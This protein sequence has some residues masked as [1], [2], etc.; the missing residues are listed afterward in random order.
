MGPRAGLDGSGKSRPHRDSI[1]EELEYTAQYRQCAHNVA[2]RRVGVTSVVRKCVCRRT[3]VKE[4]H[5]PSSSAAVTEQ[6]S[7]TSTHPLG[8]TG[9][10][11]GSLY[12]YLFIYLYIHI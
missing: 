1:A 8:H 5:S 2:F 10:V 7:Y 6:Y 11:A 12:L 3:D 4:D 9:P